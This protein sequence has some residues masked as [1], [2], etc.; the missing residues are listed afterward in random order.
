MTNE[1][2]VPAG[3][4]AA[5]W[6][7]T[8]EAVRLL[9]VALGAALSQQ[10]E[11]IARL[12]QTIAEQQQTIAQLK[13]TVA[14]QQ[15]ELV[16]LGARVATLT[17]RVQQNSQNSSKPPSSDGPHIKPR[18]QQ[19][20]SGRRAGGQAGH[21]GHWRPL[22]PESQ[23]SEVVDVRPATCACCRQAL[24]GDDPAPSRRQIVDLPPIVLWVKEVR[25]HA[26]VCP[27]C[28]ATT[29]GEDPADLP[30][31]SFGPR[32]VA[33]IGYLVGAVHVGYRS[34]AAVMED[35]LG[36]ELSVGSV[37]ALATQAS[38]AVAAPVA[39]AQKAVRE[40][41]AVNADETSWRE[42]GKRCWLWVAVTKAVVAFCLQPWRNS[43][44]ARHLLGST[45]RGVLTSDRYSA[46]YWVDQ[47]R[48]QV[49]WAHLRRDFAAFL[50]RTGAAATIGQALLDASDDLFRLWHRVRD[51]TLSR[52]N[53]Q[54]QMV[55]IQTRVGDLLREGE[56]LTGT[57]TA[58]TCRQ[59]LRLETA[60]WTFLTVEGVE[61]TNNTAE[62]ALRSAVLWRKRSLGTKTQAGSLLVER[63]LTVVA[64]LCL[65]RRNI[66]DYLTEACD[67][68][69]S[70]RTPP[71]LLPAN[72]AA[73]AEL[74]AA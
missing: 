36:L 35:L 50:D 26:L 15:Q 14:G 44:A 51:G 5:D 63:M 37:H 25:V 66:L 28:G 6:R 31:G 67:A 4:D 21:A 9:L 38:E 43:A 33:S 30:K 42:Q 53:C 58:G 69:S 62:R 7:R 71:S 32:V 19:A 52:Q 56:A 49:C 29:R 47:T 16:R 12:E 22:V 55:S 72:A 68:A 10:Q 45:F 40:A 46:Y 20:P 60:L 70:G 3:I 8:P 54:R 18:P 73:P 59:I 11:T 1:C 13:E 64:T 17:E 2:A 23:V 27:Q 61:P 57:K 34:A 24:S 39:A 74:R 65:Q 48:R 41:E